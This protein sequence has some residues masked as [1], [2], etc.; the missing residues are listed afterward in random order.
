VGRTVLWNLLSNPFGGSVFPIN[1]ARSSVLGIK[2]Y[3]R[4]AD[5]PDQVDL[6]VTATPAATVPDIIDE[7]TAAGVCGAIV[8]SAG[9][10]E[11]GPSCL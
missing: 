11:V 2:A 10:R 6:A 8:I 9:F 5:V 1:S 4:L 7:C 3:S